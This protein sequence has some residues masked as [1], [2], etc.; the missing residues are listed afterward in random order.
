MKTP[1]GE[2]MYQKLSSKNNRWIF[3]QSWIL[4]NCLSHSNISVLV[5]QETLK[6]NN[7]TFTGESKVSM[8]KK[9]IYQCNN[10]VSQLT[11]FKSNPLYIKERYKKWPFSLWYVL[12]YYTF[13]L[14]F[15]SLE[16]KTWLNRNKLNVPPINSP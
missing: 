11:S 13:I 14:S 2:S 3:W 9:N 8:P 10:F 7:W 6:Q 1:V 12:Q 16:V 15:L 4:C 5:C